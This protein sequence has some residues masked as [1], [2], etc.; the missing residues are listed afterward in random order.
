[1]Q[2]RHKRRLF[3]HWLTGLIFASILA[4]IGKPVQPQKNSFFSFFFI[5]LSGLPQSGQGGALTF[6][7]I[8]FCLT[9]ATSEQNVFHCS[10]TKETHHVL[11]PE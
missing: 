8:P 7:P 4:A 6:M 10:V 5:R 1:M 2:F 9:P 11:L 3:R